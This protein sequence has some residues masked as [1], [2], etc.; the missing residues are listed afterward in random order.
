MLTNKRNFYFVEKEIRKK[1]FGILSTITPNNR[2][3]STGI[4]YAV[5]KRGKPLRFYCLTSKKYKKA[6]NIEKDPAIS[7][8]IPFPHY[9]IRFAPSACVQFQGEA[10]LTSF[11]SKSEI[12]DLF[13]EKRVLRLI[14]KHITPESGKDYVFIEIVPDGTLYCHGLGFRIMEQRKSHE[15]THYKVILPEV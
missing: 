8:V 10:R 12:L 7:F 13:Q 6:R 2:P 15:K 3:H 5:S 11:D 1:T 4:L 9:Y 14:N